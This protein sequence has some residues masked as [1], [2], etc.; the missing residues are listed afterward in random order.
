M[1]P[2]LRTL[3][4]PARVLAGGLFLSVAATLGLGQ[5]MALRDVRRLDGSAGV[6]AVDIVL[7]FT[8]GASSLLEAEV[9]GE[10]R[11]YLAN[12]REVAT[13]AAWALEGARKDAYLAGPSQV[14]DERCVRC[15]RA[16]GRAS[17]RPLDTY[18]RAREVAITPARP[19]FT[20]Q[21]L[22]TKI[23]LFGVGFML[24]VMGAGTLATSLPASSKLT[25]VAAGYAGLALDFGSWWLMRA[26]TGFAW[27]RIAGNLLF[28]G[29]LA[30]MAVACLFELS[31]LTKVNR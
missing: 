5:W 9:N 18:E 23:H 13:L 27:G 4:G 3:P 17:F 31:R 6:S 29:A 15:H 21:L 20:R 14:L 1:I 28:A 16:G 22:V 11:Q 10:M 24:F 26:H 30:G 19:S 12:R 25:L 8:G 7:D 2:P